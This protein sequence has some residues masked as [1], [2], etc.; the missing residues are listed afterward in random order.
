[1]K[2][3]EDCSVCYGTGW[4]IEEKDGIS[5]AK[6]CECFE[7]K[8]K[9]ELILNANIPSRYEH[10]SFDN[11]KPNNQSQRE[12]L[13]ISKKF[14]EDFPLMDVGLLFL[15][16]TGVGKTHLA[17]SICKELIK[18]KSVNCFFYD[19]REL[20]RDIQNSYSEGSE[21]TES[22]ILG[23]IFESELFVLDELGAKKTSAWAEEFIF[24]II[25]KR[26]NDNKITVF[27]SNFLD[28]RYEKEESKVKQPFGPDFTDRNDEEKEEALEDRIG[29]RLRSRLFEMCKTVEIYG[30]DF[31]KKIK[32]GSYRF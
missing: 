1:M 19:F 29:Y 18:T 25:N 11:F 4:K 3:F 5:F 31:R 8:A 17:V 28:R 27:T 30:E 26:Y 16:N 15:G 14:V 2:N 22:D 23:P 10:C 12:A 20:I 7:R 21:I 13:K 24:Y 9:E 6:R 32:Q